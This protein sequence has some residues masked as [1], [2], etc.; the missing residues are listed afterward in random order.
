M[1]PAV[2]LLP[3]RR[4]DRDAMSAAHDD[5]RHGDGSVVEVLVEWAELCPDCNAI[6]HYE[7]RGS[8]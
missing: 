3:M 6:Y 7:C 8:T 1:N 2:K 5:G 4:E